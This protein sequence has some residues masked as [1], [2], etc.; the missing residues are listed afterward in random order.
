MFLALLL[1]V[2]LS[3]VAVF[4]GLLAYT[5]WIFFGVDWQAK[6]K[7]QADLEAPAGG[8][9]AASLHKEPSVQ[10]VLDPSKQYSLLWENIKKEVT[11]V[12]GSGPKTIL[13]GVSGAAAAGELVAL[14][15][16]SG[17]G[18]STL[19]DVLAG[20]LR[21][22]SGRIL[23]GGKMAKPTFFR[24][25]ASY[26][27]QESM[28]V[29]TLTVWE[30][31]ELKM[32]LKIPRKMDQEE[33][34]E[35]LTGTLSSMG[36][37]KVK[38]SRVGGMLPGGL[39]L[40]GLSG[41]EARRLH[42]AC[43]VV[44]APSILFLDEPTSGLDS[45]SALVLMQHL[46]HLAT[47]GRTIVSSIHQPRQGIWDMFNKLVLLSEGFL[48]YYGPVDEVTHW[49][50]Y[51]L[52]YSYNVNENGL[53]ADWLLDLVSIG[54]HNSL[55]SYG[56]KTI[57]QL[58]EASNKFIQEKLNLSDCSGSVSM[59]DSGAESGLGTPS[60]SVVGSETDPDERRLCGFLPVLSYPTSFWNQLRWLMYRNVLQVM[61]NPADM[62]GRVFCNLVLGIMLGAHLYG[63]LFQKR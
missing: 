19:L 26:V 27:P 6:R 51:S 11:G 48:M 45:Y 30:T 24:S 40:R 59:K 15:G 16:P 10:F 31:L 20:R 7:K 3:S 9:K 34:E 62:A 61:R 17:A 43:G 28:F 5:G 53:P 60:G 32:N 37:T 55:H 63:S 35:L 23:V 41:G 56:F 22:T 2:L 39:S 33:K 14:C 25:I 50:Q 29:P 1:P 42:I 4:F 44:D 52:G 36:L 18:K 46:Q 21:F 13:H 49:F 8:L 57:P 54:F 47:G 58:E 12:N 38:H